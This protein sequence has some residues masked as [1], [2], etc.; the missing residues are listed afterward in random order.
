LR[1]IAKERRSTRRIPT[2][3]SPSS[4]L[5]GKLRT[6]GARP[7]GLRH[8]CRLGQGACHPY[9]CTVFLV[10]AWCCGFGPERLLCGSRRVRQKAIATHLVNGIA[11]SQGRVFRCSSLPGRVFRCAPRSRDASGT[12]RDSVNQSPAPLS[13]HE[14]TAGPHFACVDHGAASGNT[15]PVSFSDL[16]DVCYG[17]EP[18]RSL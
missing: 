5:I 15:R 9:P 18:V 16:G 11:P 3:R 7:R 4:S 8:H 14:Y 10:K 6:F 17:P 13:G 1:D 2:R 12:R